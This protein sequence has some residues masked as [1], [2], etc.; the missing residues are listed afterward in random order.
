MCYL[1]AFNFLFPFPFLVP[2]PVSRSRLVS[3]SLLFQLPQTTEVEVSGVQ[4]RPELPPIT[5]PF[6]TYMN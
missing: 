5:L 3:R 1:R 4:L 6:T 2:V